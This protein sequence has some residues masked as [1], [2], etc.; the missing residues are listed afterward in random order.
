MLGTCVGLALGQ[1]AVTQATACGSCHAAQSLHQSETPMAHAL[2]LSPD[3]PVFKLH[4]KMTLQKGPYTYMIQSREGNTTYT[5]ADA[6]GIITV[7][8]RWTAGQRM[9]T[10]ILE[11]EGHFYESLVSYYPTIDGLEITVGDNRFTPH[12]LEE[13]L[14]RELTPR[15]VKDCFGCHST[16]AISKGQ[17]SLNSLETGVT[18]DHCHV[19]SDAH[20]VDAQ[21]GMLDSA[22][23]PLHKLSS[24]DVNDFCG[25]CHRSWQTGIRNGIRGEANVRFQPYRLEN[26]KCFDGSDPRISCLAC[27]NPHESLV[28]DDVAYDA[29]CLACHAA[30]A[31]AKA[32]SS[33]T[34]EAKSCPVATSKCVTCH[35]PKTGVNTPAGLIT[36]T[37]HQIRVVRPNQ[38]YPN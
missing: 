14:G 26:S 31:P 8:V 10:W 22:P 17:L 7:P 36:F 33:I 28:R 32:V 18:C 37:D 20:L 5:V 1:N 19:G 25:Q 30:K 24:E 34:P 15:E 21:Q 12:T 27:H 13:A 6:T 9:Q 4:P 29:R 3:N 16:N 35:M 23:P 2:S 38:A 11:R